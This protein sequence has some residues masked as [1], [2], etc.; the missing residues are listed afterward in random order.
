MRVRASRPIHEKCSEIMFGGLLFVVAIACHGQ[1]A[2][3]PTV[4]RL[5]GVDSSS[6][7]K[8]TRLFLEGHIVPVRNGKSSTGDVPGPA[9][10]PPPDLIAQC[11][12][13]PSGKQRFELFANFGGVTDRAFYPPFK[14]SPGQ[15]FAPALAQANV[16]MEFLGYTHVPAVRRRWDALTEP[17][18]Q[19]RYNPPSSGS[20]NLEDSTYYLRFM[21]ALPTLRLTLGDKSAEFLTTPLLDQIRKEPLCKAAKL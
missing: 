8:F 7:I 10:G 18:G 1:Q 20:A 13:S 2:D 5:D 6:G 11:T 17:V 4:S 9:V 12:V 16:T 21:I 15:L 14:P 19:Y 3:S